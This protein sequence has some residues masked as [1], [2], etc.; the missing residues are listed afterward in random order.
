[1][2]DKPGMQKGNGFSVKTIGITG[3]VGAG[4]S[5]IL[6]YIEKNCNCRI[7]LA[8]D[9]AHR[10]EEPG[11]PC[12]RELVSLLG[13][14]VLGA[15]GFF[16]RQK[17]A[18]AIFSRKEL[19]EKVNGIVH[20]AVK[21]YI[22]SE[23]EKER[24]AGRIDAFFVEA[25]LLIEEGYGAILDALWYIYADEDVRRRR[26]TESRGYSDQK[27]EQ[28][29]ASQLSEAEFRKHCKVVIDNS[30]SLS[31]TYLQIDERLKEAG[32]KK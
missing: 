30:G 12:Y 17:M 19:L 23:I 3:G 9:A 28:I 24:A 7:L 4:K 22:L 15:D 26:L 21:T 1:M 25:A 2:T 31:D 13:T 8:D 11:Q 6:S 18:A 14:D 10:V 5:Q 32:L 16:D 27:A 29:F 20:P